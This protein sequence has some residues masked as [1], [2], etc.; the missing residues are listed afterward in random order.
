[1]HWVALTVLMTFKGFVYSFTK[2][3]ACD[4]EETK[5][6]KVINQFEMTLH[7]V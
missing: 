4:H 3:I 2:L 7:C 5:P 1:M 6:L